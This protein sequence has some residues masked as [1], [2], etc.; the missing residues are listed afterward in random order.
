MV[1]KTGKQQQ[2]R[3]NLWNWHAT[4][5]YFV[6][7]AISSLL[8]EFKIHAYSYL[9]SMVIQVPKIGMK[10]ICKSWLGKK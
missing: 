7:S 3:R 8:I 6:T 10:L 4:P 1:D 9:Y 2:Q 5:W